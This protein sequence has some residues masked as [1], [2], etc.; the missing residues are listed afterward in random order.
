MTPT[1]WQSNPWTDSNNVD[2]IVIGQQYSSNGRLSSIQGAVD[3]SQF[4]ISKKG[5]L[6]S[7]KSHKQ[8]VLF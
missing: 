6:L 4:Y 3:L 1:G 7:C 5:W 8:G 2:M